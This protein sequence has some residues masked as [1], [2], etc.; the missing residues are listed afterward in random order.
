M[1]ADENYVPEQ[2]NMYQGKQIV[3]N[4]D[5]VLF[6]A[7]NDSVL[8]FADKSIG[9]NT[10]GTVNIDTTNRG[11][12]I[13][14]SPKIIL[15]MVSDEYPKEPALLGYKTGTYLKDL[16]QLIKDLILFLAAE[17]KVTVPLTG[18]S[19]PGPNDI[20]SLMTTISSLKS[21]IG[22]S[23]EP[24]EIHSKNITLI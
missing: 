19:A 10:A 5:R 9:L 14:N 23:K 13:V 4:S 1:A 2:P 11:K 8:I 24:G 16:C 18:V 7:K 3:L 6:N 21:R 22:D 12:F 17:Y 15:G 20:S